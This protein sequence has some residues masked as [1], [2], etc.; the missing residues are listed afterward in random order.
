M[1]SVLNTQNRK[2]YKETLGGDGYICYLDCGDGNTSVYICPNS[3][4]CIH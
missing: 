4:N 2:G 3:P 1:L